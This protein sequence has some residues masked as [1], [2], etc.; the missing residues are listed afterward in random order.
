MI[1][2]IGTL[3][4]CLSVVFFLLGVLGQACGLLSVITVLALEFRFDVSG[5]CVFVFPGLDFASLS[6][7]EA[8]R[9]VAFEDLVEFS[10]FNRFFG[11]PLL[12]FFR[13]EDWDCFVDSTGGLLVV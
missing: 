10:F 6:S 1:V 11:V 8:S 2:F 13:F 9:D 4:I 7:G 3:S 12:F 5:R